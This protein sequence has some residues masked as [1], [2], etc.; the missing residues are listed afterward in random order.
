VIIV[1]EEKNPVE[2]VPK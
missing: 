2:M 1:E